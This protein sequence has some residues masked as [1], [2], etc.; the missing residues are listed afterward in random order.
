MSSSVAPG[1]SIIAIGLPGTT[2]MT[3][4]TMTAAPKSVTAIVANRSRMLR[5]NVKLRVP[6]SPVPRHW[7]QGDVLPNI[8]PVHVSRSSPQAGRCPPPDDRRAFRPCGAP[9]GRA[10]QARFIRCGSSAPEVCGVTLT[11]DTCRI[12]CT[13]WNSGITRALSAM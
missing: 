8:A 4:K 3:K 1:G 6:E 7:Y 9:E 13:Y 5:N 10:S 2:R 11:P 12:G